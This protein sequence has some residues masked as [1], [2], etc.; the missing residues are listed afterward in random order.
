MRILITG[1]AGFIGSNLVSRLFLEGHTIRVLDKLCPQIHG[2]NPSLSPLLQHVNGKCEFI[3]GDV[4]CLDTVRSALA[5]CNA[6]VHLAAET[7][8]GQSMY[9]VTKY[10]QTN[11]QGTGVLL[12]AMTE[13]KNAIRKVVV[14]SSRAVYGEGR[15]FLEDKYHYPR[16]RNEGDLSRGIFEPRCFET[17]R[18][19]QA[20]A[21]HEDSLIQPNSIYGLTKYTQEHMTLLNCNAL[22]IP[23]VALRFQNV[24]GPGQSL[25]NPYTGILSIFSTRILHGHGVDIYEDGN[26][27]R[28][29]IYID[30]V[31]DSIVLALNN[32]EVTGEVFGVG[33][34]TATS[35]LEVAEELV[36]LYG[37]DVPIKVTG[38]YRVGDIRHNFADTSKGERVLGFKAKTSFEAGI[39]KFVDWVKGQPLQDDRYGESLDILKKRGLFK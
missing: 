10:C 11:V 23:V 15:Y 19:M 35:V 37:I 13:Y 28:D 9:E 12:E 21:T 22:N 36:S 39:V 4:C 24:Y 6:V 16:A 30:D 34:G 14:A 5:G 31:V 27:S 1:G 18:V 38:S 20:V 33:T 32:E 8:T 7:G 2:D 3:H 29:F 17:G 25:S 26:E